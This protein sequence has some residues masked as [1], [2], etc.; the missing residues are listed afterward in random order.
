MTSVHIYKTLFLP[1]LCRPFIRSTHVSESMLKLSY[2][3][4]KFIFIDISK[5]ILPVFQDC[6]FPLGNGRTKDYSQSQYILY[7]QTQTQ[8]THL[9]TPLSL[10]GTICSQILCIVC[11]NNSYVYCTL[12]Y[13]CVTNC[14]LHNCVR[15]VTTSALLCETEVERG[16]EPEVDPGRRHTGKR[17]GGRM[18]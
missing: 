5:I 3:F 15:W 8:S 1:L 18:P 7:I 17:R 9:H 2:E 10:V 13:Y 6:M 12:Q 16:R 4:H 11:S 14:H